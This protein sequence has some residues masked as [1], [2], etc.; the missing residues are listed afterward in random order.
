MKK[1]SGFP[2]EVAKALNY[3]VYRLLDPRNGETFYVG[4]GKGDRVF[5]HANGKMRL[6]PDED[7]NKDAKLKRIN[8]IKLAGFETIHVIHRHGMNE[9][10]A[11]EVEAALIEAYPGL[12]NVAGG[13][14]NLERGVAHADEIIRSFTAEPAKFKHHVL[15]ITI[16]RSAANM[17]V[18]TATRFAWKANEKS[19]AA[20]EVVLAVVSGVVVEVFIPH[21]WRRATKENFPEKHYY[22]EPDRFGFEGVVAP[23]NI[24]NQYL[25]KKMPKKKKG[26][27]TVFRYYKPESGLS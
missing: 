8:E 6:S 20:V 10:T 23:E 17:D 15:A 1:Y 16:N 18:Y 25:G 9:K 2:R 3:Y 7:L 26:D 13:H 11:F 19:L 12:T 24:R 5:A 27:A 21:E 22:D 14:G 4:K